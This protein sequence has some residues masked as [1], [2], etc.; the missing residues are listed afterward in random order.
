MIKKD[1]DKTKAKATPK[2]MKLVEHMCPKC[3]K[4]PVVRATKHGPRCRSC[5]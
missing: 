5:T 3:G 4:N 1:E 2:K